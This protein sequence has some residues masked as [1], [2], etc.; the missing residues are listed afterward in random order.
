[1]S[2]SRIEDR[3][4]AQLDRATPGWA[5]MLGSSEGEKRLHQ[6]AE[7]LVAPLQ[8]VLENQ[9]DER[10]NDVLSAQL[11][12]AFVWRAFDDAAD[13]HSS[14]ADGA[15]LV[16]RTVSLHSAYVMK[17]FPQIESRSVVGYYDLMVEACD[18]RRSIHFDDIWQRCAILLHAPEVLGYVSETGC[19]VY[20]AYLN[21]AGLAHDA[22]D[23]LDDWKLGT[24]TLPTI[25][26]QKA[27]SPDGVLTGDSLRSVFDSSRE[28]INNALVEVKALGAAQLYPRLLAAM[29]R[30]HSIIEELI[31]LS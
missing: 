6:Y 20:R 19:K 16:A 27:C 5:N 28:L 24:A 4:A 25:W 31:D 22:Q 14:R 23:L 2:V 26:L 7:K 12:A 3:I 17:V 8:E 29:Q 18:N 15:G 11:L 10:V 21:V 9:S 13:G 30:D 1:M